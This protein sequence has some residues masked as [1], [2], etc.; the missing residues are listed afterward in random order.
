MCDLSDVHT[1]V[2]LIF[3]K[4]LRFIRC[5]CGVLLTNALAA[6][7]IRCTQARDPREQTPDVAEYRDELCRLA[8]KVGSLQC[9]EL[10]RALGPRQCAELKAQLHPGLYLSNVLG[11]KEFGDV[12]YPRLDIILKNETGD[13]A[14]WHFDSNAFYFPQ[15]TTGLTTE[16]AVGGTLLVRVDGKILEI[17]R[18]CAGKSFSH[19]VSTE[20]FEHRVRRLRSGQRFVCCFYVPR[21]AVPL[22]TALFRRSLSVNIMFKRNKELSVV[23]RQHGKARPAW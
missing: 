9:A 11:V 8:V 12:W 7:T 5:T 17:S 4:F 16:D 1:R 13:L 23:R 19:I 6:P 10:E 14:I 2:L 3:Q 15:V 22:S 18:P 20:M 21:F